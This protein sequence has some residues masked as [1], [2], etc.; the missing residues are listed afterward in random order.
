LYHTNGGV[1]GTGL[2]LV[3]GVPVVLTRKFSAS[4]YW[5]ACI[6]YK[7]TVRNQATITEN[8]K[9]NETSKVLTV[10]LLK[11]QVL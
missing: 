7:C 1:L 10:V 6:K 11:I 5:N 4:A 8:S 2:T 3:F 9:K